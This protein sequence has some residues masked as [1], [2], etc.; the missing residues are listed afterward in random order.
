VYTQGILRQ[1]CAN[2]RSLLREYSE[3]PR[4]II[5][6]YTENDRRKALPVKDFK[7]KSAEIQTAKSG[8]NGQKG[9]ES[10]PSVVPSEVVKITNQS[11]WPG[12]ERLP[13]RA[14]C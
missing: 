1:S 13:V 5:G 7:G 11:L 4:R 12:N 3:D 2:L 6:Q 14:P 8:K 10:W 9:H